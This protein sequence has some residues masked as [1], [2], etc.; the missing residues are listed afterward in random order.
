[1]TQV[2]FYYIIY[3]EGGDL[4]VV[5]IPEARKYPSPDEL[6]RAMAEHE[7]SRFELDDGTIHDVVL[8]CA[9]PL[10]GHC[11]V[12]GREPFNGGPGVVDFVAAIPVT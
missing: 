8:T 5:V 2:Y 12:F 10:D 4:S 6:Q 1:L 9:I 11:V 7:V 3:H